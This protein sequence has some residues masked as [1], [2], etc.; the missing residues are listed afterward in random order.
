MDF[1]GIIF[2]II[3]LWIAHELV[4]GLDTGEMEDLDEEG[5]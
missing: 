2:A 3:S 5:V 4:E 1:I